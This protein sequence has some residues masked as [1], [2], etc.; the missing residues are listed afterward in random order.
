[1]TRMT[2]RKPGRHRGQRGLSPFGSVALRL[3]QMLAKTISKTFP[4]LLKIL[5]IKLANDDNYKYRFSKNV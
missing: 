1:M 5:H 4:T 2:V 3:K